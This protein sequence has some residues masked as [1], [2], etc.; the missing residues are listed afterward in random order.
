[1]IIIGYQGIGKST[2]AN[3]NKEF[4]D[5]ESGCFWINDKRYDEWYI[6]Y[7]QI[8]EH[9]SKQGKIVFV[10]SHKQ[11]RE[12]LKNSSEEVICCV[13]A[14]ELKEKWIYRLMVRY[15]VSGLDK[16]YRAYINAKDRYTDNIN[17][18]LNDGFTNIIIKRMD[19]SLKYIINKYIEC[20]DTLIKIQEKI[21]ASFNK[22]S[23]LI[24]NYGDENCI[25]KYVENIGCYSDIMNLISSN[26]IFTINIKEESHE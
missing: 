5:L 9:L 2:L 15:S 1:M 18:L 8:A 19:Y 4:I 6:P 22:L 13:P 16:D 7:I 12:A 24:Y 10:S 17:E 23:S 26:D 11:V 3:N 20:K 21:N 25:L 14:L